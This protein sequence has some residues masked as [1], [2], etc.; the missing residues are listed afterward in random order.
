MRGWLGENFRQST[1]AGY[2][3]IVR[4]LVGYHFLEVGWAKVS[5][6]F[7]SGRTLPE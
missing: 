7:Y 4:I 6:G 1:Y 2:L 5:R 3:A